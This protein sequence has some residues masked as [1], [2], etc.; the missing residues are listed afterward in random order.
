[1][2]TGLV[3]TLGTVQQVETEAAGRRLVVMASDLAPEMSIGDS[4]AVNGACLTLVERS[5]D[6]LHFQAGPETLQRTNLGEL[7]PGNPVNL[8]RPLA[9]ADRLGGH[10]VQGHVDGLGRIA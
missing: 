7:K 10:F 5:G 9:V 8:E 4:I 1:M 6:N 2:F 3:E